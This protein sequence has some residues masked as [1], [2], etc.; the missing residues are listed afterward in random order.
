MSNFLPITTGLPPNRSSHTRRTCSRTSRRS[1]ASAIRWADQ[2][3]TRRDSARWP[4]W[5]GR[6]MGARP[7]QL[8]RRPFGS[9]TWHA[10]PR[11]LV[12]DLVKSAPARATRGDAVVWAPSGSVRARGPRLLGA[13]RALG[14]QHRLFGGAL[15]LAIRL[16]RLRRS[17]LDHAERAGT[18]IG[19]P[20]SAA[21]S[22]GMADKGDAD[23]AGSFYAREKAI[24]HYFNRPSEPRLWEMGHTDPRLRRRL[25]WSRAVVRGSPWH[26]TAKHIRRFA[27]DSAIRQFLLELFHTRVGDRRVV[28][29]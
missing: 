6:G 14:D 15:C 24:P 21:T 28:E 26:P 7:D 2:R 18:N 10:R 22:R 9:G 8:G 5:N 25:P 19:V 16:G 4:V 11:V 1:N 20:A 13:G 23:S 27:V 17:V 3:L 29:G 12:L